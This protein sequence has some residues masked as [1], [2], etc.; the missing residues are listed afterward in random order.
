MDPLAPRNESGRALHIDGAVDPTVIRNARRLSRIWEMWAPDKFHEIEVSGSGAWRPR[1]LERAPDIHLFSGGVDS[2]FS[3]VQIGRRAPEPGHVLTVHGTDYTLENT[4]GFTRLLMKTDPLLEDLNYR[5]VVIRSNVAQHT[6]KT[7]LKLTHGFLFAGCLFLMRQIFHEGLIAADSTPE[8]DML[9]F[10][11]GTN[12]VTNGY[13]A[14]EDFSMRTLSLDYSRADKT[15]LLSRHPLACST[16][17]CCKVRAKRPE[18]CGLCTKCVRTKIMFVA[19]TGAVPPIFAEAA[20]TEAQVR[21]MDLSKRNEYAH[22][23]DI[24]AKAR[25]CGNLDKI[26]GFQEHLSAHRR[27]QSPA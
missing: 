20:L 10:P 24:Y 21:S 27:A 11:W 13:F 7:N 2:A 12:H 14:G 23:C 16:I 9:V 15:E 17:S 26:P 5:R 25:D 1:N 22:F 4:R 18:N 6:K 3:L 19:S 8:L